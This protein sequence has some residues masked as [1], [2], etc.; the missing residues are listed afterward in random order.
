MKLFAI[1]AALA[2]MVG[3]PTV[4]GAH[5]TDSGPPLIRDLP[6]TDFYHGGGGGP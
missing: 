6:Q 4:S 2:L 5:F 3:I 1:A